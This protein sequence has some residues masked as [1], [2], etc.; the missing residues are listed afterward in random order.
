ML[1]LACREGEKIQRWIHAALQAA[2][3]LQ[4]LRA[5]GGGWKVFGAPV[6]GRA[7]VYFAAPN[8]PMACGAVLLR[9]RRAAPIERG[10]NMAGAGSAR[11]GAALWLAGLMG[12]GLTGPGLAEEP[13]APPAGAKLLL[14]AGADGVQIYV[15]E[16]K[17]QDFAWVFEAPEATLFDAEGRQLG[18][19]SAGPTWTLADGSEVTGKIAGKQ[20]SPLPRAIPWLLLEV[21]TH[22]ATGRLAE[23]VAIRRVETKGGAAPTGGCDEAHKGDVARMRYSATYQFFGR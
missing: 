16:P 5:G 10:K 23:A 2:G 20:A 11:W 22:D 21:K 3:L 6:K 15:C 18:T 1:G 19:H 8:P 7:F 12:A 4:I 13:L 17:D 14:E 9:P